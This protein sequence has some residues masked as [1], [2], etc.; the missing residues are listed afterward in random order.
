MSK[1]NGFRH[2]IIFLASLIGIIAVL[3]YATPT[4]PHFTI[5]STLCCE[6]SISAAC[7]SCRLADRGAIITTAVEHSVSAH[8]LLTGRAITWKNNQL[9]ELVGFAS[10]LSLKNQHFFRPCKCQ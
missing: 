9:G 4:E 10:D 2:K 7:Y 6:N 5:R 3:H 8:A 1:L